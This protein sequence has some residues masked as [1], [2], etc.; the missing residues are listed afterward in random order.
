MTKPIFLIAIFLCLSVPASASEFKG[1]I[2]SKSSGIN[3]S[4][5]RK[6]V[7]S[8]SSTRRGMPASFSVNKRG[9]TSAINVGSAPP[10]IREILGERQKNGLGIV[11]T[12]ALISLF[13]RHDL[14]ESDRRWISNQLANRHSS[15]ES[16]SEKTLFN[17][18]STV[19]FTFKNIEKPFEIGTGST[20]QVFAVNNQK[21]PIPIQC[22]GLPLMQSSNSG[23]GHITIRWLPAASGAFMITCS[24]NQAIER[25]LVF[26]KPVDSNNF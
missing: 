4:S 5:K 2:S 11:T 10:R 9:T 24:A 19:T 23:L 3:S 20:L 25:R 6:S 15:D 7:S 18:A 1:S 21:R 26:V 8:I 14:S 22:H 16:E 17:L 12:A 13:S